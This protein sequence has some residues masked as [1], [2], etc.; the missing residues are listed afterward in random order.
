MGTM[1]LQ[2][3]P[4]RA[5][6]GESSPSHTPHGRLY[7]PPAYMETTGDQAVVLTSANHKCAF[8][9]TPEVD[10]ALSSLSVY[11]NAVVD[12]DALLTM[13]VH[14]DDATATEPNGFFNVST[15]NA[16]QGAASATSEET[17]F[18]A[19]KAIDGSVAADNGWRS[20]SP[21][22]G[23]SPQDYIIDFGPGVSLKINKIL[24]F[25]F[26]NPDANVR[27]YPLAFAIAF[28]QSDENWQTIITVT[29]Q[30]DPGPGGAAQF[31]GIN[32]TGSRRMR[33]RITD[34]NGVNGYCSI[35]EIKVFAAQD[36][37]VPGTLL[38]SLGTKVVGADA[39]WLRHT[40]SDCQLQRG[41]RYWIQ[42]AGQEG[43]SFSQSSRRWNAN[44]GS[45]FPDSVHPADGDVA[46]KTTSDGGATWTGNFQNDKPAMLNVVLNSTP[47]HSPQLYY[48]RCSGQHIHLPGVGV[49]AIPAAGV[50]LSM[51]G[52]SPNQ[53]LNVWFNEDETISAD[54]APRVLSEGIEVKEGSPT[55]RFIGIV[56]PIERQPGLQAPIDVV[57]RRL[58]RDL[59][60]GTIC[61]G[62][63]CPYSDADFALQMLIGQ[64]WQE[65]GVSGT[66]YKMEFLALSGD[67]L[68]MEPFAAMP[69]TATPGELAFGLDGHP[70]G[71]TD[72]WRY[73]VLAPNNTLAV[74]SFLNKRL[75]EG[76]H[77]IRP[78]FLV[79][80]TAAIEYPI[81]FRGPGMVPWAGSLSVSVAGTL[82]RSPR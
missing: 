35:G 13:T 9:F 72:D 15:T 80:G 38:Q 33:I 65:M 76:Y 62:K 19:S 5:A 32:G 11:K 49:K 78:Y 39:G 37:P 8:S 22:S 46:I 75:E 71:Y 18:E 54:A 60:E 69:L 63:R 3:A 23:G 68:D 47:N 74:R 29:D 73:T 14:E 31:H 25:S 10:F 1:A 42:F 51:E 12:S 53:T 20:T 17:G 43:K 26:N 16:M 21:P 6:G 41:K 79:L 4:Q 30:V 45:M 24:I 50:A 81:M 44:E 64:S 40:F 28:D 27:A 56:R 52:E 58:V 34:R 36:K 61:I 66:D 77:T 55:S 59:H 67:V 57:D 2:S 7:V 82:R 70:P 48:G